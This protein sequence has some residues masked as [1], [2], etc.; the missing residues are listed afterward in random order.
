M[1]LRLVLI[2]AGCGSIAAAQEQPSPADPRL[3][4]AV[5]A[6]QKAMPCV[7]NIS[8]ERLVPVSDPFGVL[9]DRWYGRHYQYFRKTTSPVGS[10][11][12][13]CCGGL[14]V[15]NH[16]VVSRAS[17]IYIRLHDESTRRARLVAYDVD[18]DL[19]LLRLED[20]EEDQ[21]L[22]AIELALPDDLYLGE[23]VMAVGNPF[24]IG[25]TVTQGVLSATKRSLTEG[26]VTFHDILQTDAA[27]NPGNSGGPLINLRG[28]LIG[29]NIAIRP[30]SEGIGFA[31][32]MGRIE[33]VLARWLVPSRFSLA[34]CGFFPHTVMRDGSAVAAVGEVI[35]ASPA[36]DAGLAPG[37]YITRINE[38]PVHRAI[39]VGKI[40]WQLKPGDRIRLE[41]EG[42]GVKECVVGTMTPQL[43]VRRRLG[44]QLQELSEPLCQALGL[45]PSLRGL[46]VS[47]VRPESQFAVLHVRRGDIITQVNETKTDTMA[48]I[49][50]V[51]K[52]Q[53]PGS[54]VRVMLIVVDRFRGQ[55][56]PRRLDID[57]TLN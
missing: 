17:Q 22:H 20:D 54:T 44:I 21:S 36:A 56:A 8:T 35:A 16:H 33:D 41:I 55:V 29:L 18:N 57:V 14:I 37:D 30:E 4:P 3:Q 40:L 39:D 12:L 42:A 1:A 50:E 27:I 47:E 52:G 49:F 48:D 11:V 2:L 7:V 38:K 28:Q 23:T 24:G 9:Y 34:F 19:A 46:A 51:L 32:P 13:V 6:V 45:R 31:I 15:T 26:R 53:P 5:R 25:T 10:G 43:L